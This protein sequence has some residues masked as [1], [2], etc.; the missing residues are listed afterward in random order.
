MRRTLIRA[1]GNAAVLDDHVKF[2]L[3][4]GL[5]RLR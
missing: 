4:D 3:G 5:D 2:K 1:L